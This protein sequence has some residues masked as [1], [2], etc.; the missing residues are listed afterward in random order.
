MC[1]QFNN[2]CCFNTFMYRANLYSFFINFISYRFLF[3]HDKFNMLFC[4]KDN[5]ITW[6][7]SHIVLSLII[8][9]LKLLFWNNFASNFNLLNFANLLFRFWF[10]DSR[11]FKES[12]FLEFCFCYYY[13]VSIV[14]NLLFLFSVCR[15]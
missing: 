6:T 9:F 8:K 4:E 12:Y 11:A 3:W 15:I 10:S 5:K 1:H 7:R 2:D 13:S 14:L